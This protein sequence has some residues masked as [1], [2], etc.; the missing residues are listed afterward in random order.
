MEYICNS[1]HIIIVTVE[2]IGSFMHIIAAILN[3]LIFISIA[4]LLNSLAI[5]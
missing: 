1:M 4:F 5:H 3:I 2:Y